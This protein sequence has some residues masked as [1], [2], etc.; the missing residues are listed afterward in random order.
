MLKITYTEKGCLIEPS[1]PES[2][3]ELKIRRI[4]LSGELRDINVGADRITVYTYGK[5]EKVYDGAKKIIL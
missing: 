2:V 4:V 3:K 5:G 1:L